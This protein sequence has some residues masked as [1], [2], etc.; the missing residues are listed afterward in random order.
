MT[1]K[2]SKGTSSCSVDLISG[3]NGLY[4]ES[5]HDRRQWVERAIGGL[6]WKCQHGGW[7]KNGVETMYGHECM[8]SAP[9][10]NDE[11]NADAPDHHTYRYHAGHLMQ[12]VVNDPSWQ[13]GLGVIHL[14]PWTSGLSDT[15]SRQR[16]VMWDC[17]D[18]RNNQ[19]ATLMQRL[20]GLSVLTDVQ[21]QVLSG[22]KAAQNR[23][24]W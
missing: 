22:Y 13:G 11:A 18:N 19:I 21:R 10:G 8:G 15:G 14:T 9:V 7:H 16:V 12:Q 17:P 23:S 24:Q 2:V 5:E 6:L 3:M 20:G 1:L 4:Q